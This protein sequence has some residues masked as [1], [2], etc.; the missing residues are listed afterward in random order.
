MLRTKLSRTRTALL[1]G[2]VASAALSLGLI[3]LAGDGGG[4]SA[5][6]Y[7]QAQLESSGRPDYCD[8]PPYFPPKDRS[9]C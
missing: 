6:A 5:D 9:L 2:F 3:G 4:T 1:L 8:W 7:Y